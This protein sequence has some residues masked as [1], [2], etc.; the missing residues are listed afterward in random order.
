[1]N[2]QDLVAFVAALVVDRSV[3]APEADRVRAERAA[4]RRARRIVARCHGLKVGDVPGG[5]P[6]RGRAAED[7]A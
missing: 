1:M 2:P 3:V 7:E 6:S 4:I 5:G